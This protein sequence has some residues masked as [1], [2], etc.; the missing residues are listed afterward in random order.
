MSEHGLL[1]VALRTDQ[2]DI[3]RR[4]AVI[5]NASRPSHDPP[6]TDP[7]VYFKPEDELVAADLDHLAHFVGMAAVERIGVGRV[8]NLMTH[9]VP[10]DGPDNAQT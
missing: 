2:P 7:V 6:E 9:F 10:P 5:L 3:Q 8:E 4:I 1:I